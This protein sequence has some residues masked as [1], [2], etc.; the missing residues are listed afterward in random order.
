MLRTVPSP[1]APD[2]P[3]PIAFDDLRV[4]DQ[5]AIEGVNDRTAIRIRRIDPVPYVYTTDLIIHR[6][7]L[8]SL[9]GGH[10]VLVDD[11]TRYFFL[12]G[13]IC[14]DDTEL[15]DVDVTPDGTDGTLCVVGGERDASEW[16]SG[17]RSVLGPVLVVVTVYGEIIGDALV[18]RTLM[19]EFD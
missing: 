4:G 9:P 15:N 18:A 1:A 10:A 14:D 3:R 2:Q 8:P 7:A 16:A 19:A 17:I 11:N 5:V 6:G 12:S 13:V